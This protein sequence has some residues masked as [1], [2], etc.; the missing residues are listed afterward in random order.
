MG[1]VRE[2]GVVAEHDLVDLALVELVRCCGYRAVVLDCEQ[3]T[4]DDLPV[5]PVVLARTGIR[6]AQVSANPAFADAAIAVME[7]A[8]M[9]VPQVRGIAVI[10]S[11]DDAV[12]HLRAFLESALGAGSERGV[13]PLSPREREILGTYVL[14]A[15]VEQTAAEHYV[16]GSTVRTHYRR[17][18][19]RYAN[20]GRPV[21][22]KAQ[23]LLHMVADGW[24]DVPE[25]S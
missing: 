7:T 12:K 25:P 15:T 10:P 19:A 4:A 13:V 9:V 8:G 2:V 6:V 1:E 14:G 23:L 17:V 5:T 11:N 18:T 22:N 16:A 3:D 20:A 21:T 24:I